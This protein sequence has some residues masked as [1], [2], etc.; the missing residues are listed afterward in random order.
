MT[1]PSV[2]DLSIAA[3]QARRR[4]LAVR[5]RD[6]E[7]YERGEL[8]TWEEPGDPGCPACPFREDWPVAEWCATCRLKKALRKVADRTWRRLLNA[9]PKPETGAVVR[10]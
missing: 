4:W 5:W 6:C 9:I 3:V 7:F 2:A 10:P 1:R 8:S